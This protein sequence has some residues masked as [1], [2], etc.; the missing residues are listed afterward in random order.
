LP[1]AERLFTDRWRETEVGLKQGVDVDRV[2]SILA[3]PDVD[4][5]TTGWAVHVMAKGMDKFVGVQKA[6]ELL[7]ID[8]R[9]VAS[10]GDSENDMRMIKGCGW[11]VAIGNA[12]DLAKDVASY[13]TSGRNG[14]GVVEALEWLGLID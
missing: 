7:D 2:R 10:I 14:A 11:G 1:S 9:D 12:D 13:V 8:V 5:Q 6:C 3:G 4:I